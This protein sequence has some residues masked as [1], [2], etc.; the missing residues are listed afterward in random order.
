MP[1]SNTPCAL[2]LRRVGSRVPALAAALF[3][4][5]ALS[6]TARAQADFTFYFEPRALGSASVQGYA[7]WTTPLDTVQLNGFKVPLRADFST[8]PRPAPTPSPL[9]RGWSIPLVSSA[10]VEESQDSLRWHRPDGRI[11][12]FMRERGLTPKSTTDTGT[13]EYIAMDSSWRAVKPA[14]ARTYTLTHLNS[15]AELVYA[16]G[17]LVKFCFN[18]PGEGG[19]SY[20]INYNRLRR[21]VKLWET[22]TGQGVLEF[23]YDDASRAAELRLGDPNESAS[24][25]TVV[26]GYSDIALNSFPAGPYLT[27]ITPADL[28][29]LA[30]SY[31]ADG[32]EA[33]RARFE[34]LLTG[35]GNTG[36]GWVAASGFLKEDDGATYKI[37]NP[38]LVNQG[39][40]PV[41][42]TTPPTLAV[43]KSKTTSKLAPVADYNWYP[44]DAQITRTDREGKSDYRYYDRSRGVYTRTNKDG[45]S[46]VTYYLLSP[47]PMNG[48]VR[49]V[50]EV[51]GGETTVKA[52]YAYDE[53][54][55]LVRSIDSSGSIILREY[56][57]NGDFVKTI[58]DGNLISE[59]R[60]QNGE[61]TMLREYSGGQTKENTWVKEPG[62][63]RIV[64]KLNDVMIHSSLTHF[65]AQGR[66]KRREQINPNHI[67]EYTYT[68][69]GHN[70]KNWIDGQ[71]SSTEYYDQNK[72]RTKSAHADGQVSHWVNAGNETLLIYFNKLGVFSGASHIVDNKF[73]AP[74]EGE[75]HLQLIRRFAEHFPQ[76]RADLKMILPSDQF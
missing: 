19:Q 71:P 51:R 67:G 17:L 65:D 37:I 73:L 8:D 5:A 57:E 41:N 76:V 32:T 2:Q 34:K 3:I 30:I 21:P 26:F 59:E 44:E 52:R 15:G 13:T 69:K 45:V 72:Q 7:L 25:K 47:G 31:Q 54:G 1:E 24:V 63:E 35:T 36:L 56:L 28:P 50:E 42:S 33:N 16:D 29:P 14:K 38:S 49:K 46:E 10:L 60:Y 9:G 62:I 22:R 64:V 58:K 68:G 75:S 27:K 66:I 4:V 40:K 55:R 6:S 18:R 20:A 48:K 11:F 23:I 53:A 39:K 70:E 74:R 43:A 12:T 61:R